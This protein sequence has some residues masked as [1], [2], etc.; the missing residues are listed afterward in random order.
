LL[1]S[2]N[3]SNFK[4]CFGV[5]ERALLDKFNTVAGTEL[6]RL[7]GIYGGS[8][9]VMDGTRDK[10]SVTEDES[11]FYN[12]WYGSRN[13]NRLVLCSQDNFF[14]DAFPGDGGHGNDMTLQKQFNVNT[15]LNEIGAFY[16][17]LCDKGFYKETNIFPLPK[18]GTRH[19]L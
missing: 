7:P 8:N 3:L 14:I 13:I 17:A 10:V 6:K 5:W 18:G 9:C 4:G 11:Y 19:G 2:E 12:G 15:T 16:F 1:S